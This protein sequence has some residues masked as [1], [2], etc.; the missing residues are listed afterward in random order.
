VSGSV[1]AQSVPYVRNNEWY[2]AV[3]R[4]TVYLL[5]LLGKFNFVFLLCFQCVLNLPQSRVLWGHAA[6]DAVG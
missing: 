2:K 5:S 6:G 1:L 3:E 4:N